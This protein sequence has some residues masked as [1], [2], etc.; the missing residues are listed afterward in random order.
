MKAMGDEASDESMLSLAY[1]PATPG[2][3]R[4]AVAVAVIQFVACAAVL[5]FAATPLPRVAGFIVVLLTVIFVADLLT[6]VLLFTH[7]A[8]G[9]SRRP[10]ILA[11][12]YL[13]SA[14][15][16]IP[17]ALTYPGAFAPKGLLGAGPQSTAWL[18]VLWH[19]GF[20]LA[21]AGYVLLKEKPHKNEGTAQ[22]ALQ[23]F[24]W[25]VAI[26]VSLVCALTWIMTAGDRFM[27]HLYS[28]DLHLAPL[29]HYVTGTLA[30]M[31]ALLLLLMLTRP[32]ST[33]DLW[34]MV[35]ICMVISEMTAVAFVLKA[36]FNFGNYVSRSLAMAVSTIVLTA[37]I[38]ESMRLYAALSRANAQQRRAEQINLLLISELQHR[39]RNLLA[40][41]KSIAA[42]TVAAS[43]SLEAFSYPFGDRLAALSRVQSLLSDAEFA[44]VTI[45]ELVRLELRALGAEPDGHRVNVE[46]PN[47]ALPNKSVQ[48]LALALHELATNARKHGALAAPDGRL[49][50]TWQMT[51]GDADPNLAI[52][53]RE[54]GAA[55]GQ[56]PSEMRKGFGRSL[57]ERALP[58]QLDAQT[59]LE[60]M[61]DGLFCLVTIGLDPQTSRA[62]Q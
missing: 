38:S 59:Q 55:C 1:A 35:A 26:Q 41:V 5:P 8:I 58:Y 12:G 44:P 30:L 52:E 15:M 32:K 39:S 56:G 47:V 24:G 27:P 36:R 4:F 6:S 11:N 14:L 40:V 62:L 48:I 31:Y 10:L 21:V 51:N 25:S 16:I 33:L 49:N 19:F 29:A 57:I 60:F 50:V 22:S 34:L 28:D 46:G 54:H 17:H 18:N 2:Q 13:F 43:T 61:P 3:R 42:E 53:W 7:A 45:G 20:F 23:A 9:G 37:L